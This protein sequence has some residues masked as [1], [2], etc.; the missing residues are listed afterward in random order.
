M[1]EAQEA[2]LLELALG[3][4]QKRVVVKRPKGAPLLAGKEPNYQIKSKS[5]R[6]DIY[7]RLT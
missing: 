5:I 4:A 1:D 3:L 7:L 2:L 6:Y